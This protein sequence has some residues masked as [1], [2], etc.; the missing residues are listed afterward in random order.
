MC[1]VNHDC[2]YADIPLGLYIVRGDAMV[3]MGQVSDFFAQPMKKV[4]LNELLSLIEESGTGALNWDVDM[5]L[6]A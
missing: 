5:D 6:Q 3:L 4:E 1:Q 2:Y